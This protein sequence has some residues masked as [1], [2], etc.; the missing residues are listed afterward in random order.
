MWRAVTDAVGPAVR[1]TLWDYPDL[2]PGAD[3]IDDPTALVARLE[4]RARGEAPAPDEFDDAMAAFLAEEP[5]APAGDAPDDSPDDT[6]D[7]TASPKDSP[8]V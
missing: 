4:A 8:P 2:M 6:P 5:A 7:D 3:D 1:D